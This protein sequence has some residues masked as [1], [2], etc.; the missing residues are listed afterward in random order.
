MLGGASLLFFCLWFYRF[1][2]GALKCFNLVAS[3]DF[4]EFSSR[5]SAKVDS[6]R[7]G[8]HWTSISGTENIIWIT[9]TN[10]ILDWSFFLGKDV[11]ALSSLT[12]DNS[13]LIS[14]DY[15]NECIF[16]QSLEV[17]NSANDKIGDLHN[18]HFF[19]QLNFHSSSFWI[20]NVESKTKWVEKRA[21]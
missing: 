3:D 20:L 15:T 2:S 6:T 13:A 21:I 19:C 14:S 12:Y 18:M 8:Y 9:S 4:W 5:L 10:S 7:R 1:F 17:L 16:K 11:A